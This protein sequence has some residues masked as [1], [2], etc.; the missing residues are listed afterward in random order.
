MEIP[1]SDIKGTFSG[2]KEHKKMNKT[3]YL[4]VSNIK[5][6]DR[7]LKQRVS[8]HQMDNESMIFTPKSPDF[9]LTT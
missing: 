2:T 7:V 4:D 1:D 6:Y 3:F 9:K 8:T 5:L